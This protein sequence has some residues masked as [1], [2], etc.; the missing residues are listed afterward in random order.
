MTFSLLTLHPA[1][2]GVRNAPLRMSTSCSGLQSN[3]LLA[4]FGCRLFVESLSPSPLSKK[5]I[6]S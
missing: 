5:L 4:H 6:A 2:I 3:L 1:H